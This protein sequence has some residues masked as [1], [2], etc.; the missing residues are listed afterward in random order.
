M[1][2]LA[3]TAAAAS[4]PRLC[5]V[6][7]SGSDRDIDPGRTGAGKAETGIGPV[8]PDA[9]PGRR[10]RD[11]GRRHDPQRP[12]QSAF[13]AVGRAFERDEYAD[14]RFPAA[15]RRRTHGQMGRGRRA[16]PSRSAEAALVAGL[17]RGAD[18]D[19]ADAFVA[20]AACFAVA[21]AMV[22]LMRKVAPPPAPAAD[23]H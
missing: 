7:C 23:A 11:C 5:T 9:Q 14:A 20:M 3:R 13:L 12:R 1:M 10:N 17:A 21:T 16:W 6:V 15:G 4:L 8:Q 22:P 2:G 18:P 19:L